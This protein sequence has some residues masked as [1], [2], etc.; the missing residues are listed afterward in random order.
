[1]LAFWGTDLIVALSPE[2]AD[3]RRGDRA[4]CARPGLHGGGF[5]GDGHRLRTRAR[6]A[7][8]R[9]RI[10]PSRSRR[11][12]AARPPASRRTARAACWSI[13]EVAL[14]L[15]LLVGAGL[16]INSFVRLQQVAPGFDPRTGP[17]LQ[18]RPIGGPHVHP[19]AD[20]RLLPGADRATESAAGGRQRERRLSTAARRERPPPRASRSRA[21]RWIPASGRPVV[22]HMAGPE[23][24]R[25]MGI[26]VVRGRDFTERDDLNVASGADHQRGP[27]A[28]AFPE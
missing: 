23:Y 4:R 16:L 3:A 2:I 5:A 6:A 12:G 18:R 27:G 22:I 1:M 10:W 14:A 9:R 25:T 28:A 21:G 24:F 19:A 13:A 8:F 17:G 15:V 26:P 11:A 7:R 20:R